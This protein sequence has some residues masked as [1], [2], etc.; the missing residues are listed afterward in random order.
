MDQI[1]A[2]RSFVIGA[3]IVLCLAAVQAVMAAPP[4]KAVVGVAHTKEGS[5]SVDNNVYTTVVSMSVPAGKYQVSGSIIVSN[6]TGSTIDQMACN[7]YGNAN[8]LDAF[9]GTGDGSDLHSGQATSFPVIG[10]V[11]MTA[12]G[13]IRIECIS[14]TSTL[15]NVG[16]RLVAVTLADIV[17]AP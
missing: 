8:S 1:R 12:A 17:N 4:S 11:A 7:A 16:A 5:N 10:V 13:T 2:R 14:S 3:G 6:Q 15:Q 9:V